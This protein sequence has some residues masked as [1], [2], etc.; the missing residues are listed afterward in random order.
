[1]GR[2][3]V[4]DEAWHRCHTQFPVR[5]AG[6][7]NVGGAGGLKERCVSP[8]GSAS[9][10]LRRWGC[11]RRLGP[12]S[13]RRGC[14]WATEGPLAP[15]QPFP[16]S[17]QAERLQAWGGA[18]V[19][20][21]RGPLPPGPSRTSGC[22]AG[23]PRPPSAS[24]ILLAAAWGAACPPLSQAGRLRP[25]PALWS[26]SQ[27]GPRSQVCTWRPRPYTPSGRPW[28]PLGPANRRGRLAQGSAQDC[29]PA[30]L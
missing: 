2:G 12:K 9:W 24:L 17:G 16:R 5:P 21:E 6:I 29:R 8:P 22:G 4:G 28:G 23:R 11:C 13:V 10:A 3:L 18:G 7:G 1:M 20:G 19:G 15:Q 26:P 30:R 25:E 27:S 14:P